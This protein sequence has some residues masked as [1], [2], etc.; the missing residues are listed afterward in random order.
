MANTSYLN[1]DQIYLRTPE[2]E[3]IDIMYQIENDTELWEVAAVT[4]PY[5]RYALKQYIANSSHDIFVDNQLRLMIVGKA[6]NQIIGIIDLSDFDPLHNR[7]AVGVVILK[8][9]RKMGY[10]TRALKLLCDYSFGYLHLRQLYAYIPADN[11][12]SIKLFN[13]QGFKESGLLKDWIR[14]DDNYKDAYL[15]QLIKE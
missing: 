9:Y 1:D 6:D 12:S 3:D 2:P 5:S 13:G 10:A 11:I 4:V 14:C 8:E 7:A 15:L